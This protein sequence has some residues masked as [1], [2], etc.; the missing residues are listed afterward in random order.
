MLLAEPFARELADVQLAALA[1]LRR[2][3]VAYVG[4]VRPDGYLRASAAAL[5]VLDQ[6]VE[7]LGHV[8]VAQVP[9]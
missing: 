2:P 6:L 5:E 4:V 1:H 3:R 7:R 9:R 8:S